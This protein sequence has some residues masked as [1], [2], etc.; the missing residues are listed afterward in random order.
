MRF[1]R[2]AAWVTGLLIAFAQPCL[3]EPVD[4]GVPG[5]IFDHD[6]PITMTD[7]VGV[8]RLLAVSRKMRR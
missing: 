8:V 7:G 5:M 4:S 2:T 1:T 3:A 6:V